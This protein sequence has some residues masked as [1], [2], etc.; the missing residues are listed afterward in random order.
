ME[1]QRMEGGGVIQK[2]EALQRLAGHSILMR[3]IE[4]L[5]IVRALHRRPRASLAAGKPCW[6]GH[7]SWHINADGPAICSTLSRQDEVNTGLI[8][9]RYFD[10][11]ATA[12]ANETSG[13]V[14]CRPPIGLFCPQSGDARIGENSACGFWN[15][16]RPRRSGVR[17]QGNVHLMLRVE[18]R[19]GLAFNCF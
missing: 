18:L 3:S 13:L 10:L 6:R 5:V 2:N 9:E 7:L 15:S 16:E 4:Q 19:E 11:F 12:V 1:R 17:C 14:R 8:A